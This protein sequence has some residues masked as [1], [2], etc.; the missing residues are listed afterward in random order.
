MK[1]WIAFLLLLI[2]LFVIPWI[3]RES[4]RKDIDN[5]PMYTFGLITRKTGSLKNGSSWHYKYTY[6][7]K[8][9]EDYKPTDINYQVNL[10][11]WFL[12]K[13]SSENPGSSRIIYEFKSRKDIQDDSIYIGDTIPYLLLRLNPKGNRIW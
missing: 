6:K 4:K 12:V 3:V 8:T 7:N 1:T 13:F 2:I 9:Y 11:D 5:H 10:G